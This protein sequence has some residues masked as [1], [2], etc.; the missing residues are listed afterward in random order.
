ALADGRMPIALSLELSERMQMAGWLYW[1]IYETRFRK[2]DF[3]RRFH[4]PLEAVYGRT[5]RLLSLLGLLTEGEDKVALTD[6]GAYWLHTV[7]DL[8]SIDY[9]GKLWGTSRQTPWPAEIRLS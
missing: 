5:L 8:F 9:I 2:D 3:E 4:V 1:R 7:Q 6:A